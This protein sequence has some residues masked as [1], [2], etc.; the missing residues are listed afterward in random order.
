MDPHLI[1]PLL[2]AKRR[3]YTFEDSEITIKKTEDPF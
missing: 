1:D 2:D 3:F